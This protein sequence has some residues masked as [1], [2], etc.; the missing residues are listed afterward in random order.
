MPFVSVRDIRMY[1]EIRGNGPHV[2]FISGTRRRTFCFLAVGRAFFLRSTKAT[3]DG[4]L[5]P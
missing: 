3:L 1:Y 4:I 5:T 2:L